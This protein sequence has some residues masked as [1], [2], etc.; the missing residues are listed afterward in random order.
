MPKKQNTRANASARVVSTPPKGA[1]RV[2]VR[3]RRTGRTMRMFVGEARALHAIKVI[4]YIEA[5][6]APAPTYN[7]RDMVAV[8]PAAVP[9]SIP[10]I[11]APAPVAVA[12]DDGEA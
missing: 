9:L 10:I 4:D 8:K 6:P 1:M 5:A 2:T 12:K 7:R 3:V 11:A